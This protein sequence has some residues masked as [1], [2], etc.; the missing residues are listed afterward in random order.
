MER[1]DRL[2]AIMRERRLT[3][4]ALAEKAGVTRWCI[5]SILC[6]RRAGTIATWEKIA[7][8]L[9]LT[10]TELSGR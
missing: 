8:A 2:R 10:L 6:G 5:D 1:K 3:A 9:D 7:S 4:S